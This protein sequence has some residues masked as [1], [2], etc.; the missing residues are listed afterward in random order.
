MQIYKYLKSDLMPFAKLKQ[1][2][3]QAFKV[4]LDKIFPF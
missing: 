3:V 1:N 2:Y 4:F